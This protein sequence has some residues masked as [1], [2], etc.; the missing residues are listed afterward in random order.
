MKRHW[1]ALIFCAAVVT[2]IG[3]SV[4]LYRL[5][6]DS[7]AKLYCG[8]DQCFLFVEQYYKGWKFRVFESF[9]GIPTDRV[10]VRPE[11]IVF[12]L[13]PNKIEQFKYPRILS[14]L[15]IYDGKVYGGV[16]RWNGDGYALL[17]EE[18]QK[19][20]GR[21]SFKGELLL[22][23][24]HDGWL[25]KPL[26]PRDRVEVTL[27]GHSLI[28]ESSYEADGSSSLTL[29]KGHGAKEKIWNQA[30]SRFVVQKTYNGIFGT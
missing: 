20:F 9:V 16:W 22:S 15:A 3:L 25:A 18:Q 30:G 8:R 23:G 13:S 27:N 26:K 4:P 11:T 1:L 6:V 7:S 2:I 17:N 28:V 10:R 29:D 24:E 14:P 21:A 12:R 5:R 19:E